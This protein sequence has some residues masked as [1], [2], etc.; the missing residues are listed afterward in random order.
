MAARKK[1]PE[2]VN[3]GI[4]WRTLYK[5]PGS[6]PDGT[7]M[8][9]GLK[10]LSVQRLLQLA[11]WFG[12]DYGIPNEFIRRLMLNEARATMGA[13]WIGLQIAKRAVP[14]ARELDFNYDEHFEHL[15]DVQP[16]AKEKKAPPTSD[17]ATTD[18]TDT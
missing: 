1:A 10:D 11:S 16:E 15:E 4:F 3:D 14:D 12:D 7:P 5:G 2:P 17:T 18:S 8:R 6:A 9:L 13:V